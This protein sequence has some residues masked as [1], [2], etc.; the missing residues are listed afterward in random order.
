MIRPNGSVAPASG[1]SHPAEV[2]P[3]VPGDGAR[4]LS[5]TSLRATVSAGL[6]AADIV[7]LVMSAVG[8]DGPVRLVS[9]LV[10]GVIIPG[11]AVVGLLRLRDAALEAALSFAVSLALLMVAAQI[12]MTGHAWHLQALEIG[13]C[14]VTIPSLVWQSKSGLRSAA[15]LR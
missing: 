13:T 8:L 11:W 14:A 15:S 4:W 9:G 6:L 3:A 1:S 5:P 10:L 2:P 7:A 12:L